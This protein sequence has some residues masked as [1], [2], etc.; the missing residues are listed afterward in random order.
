MITIC[1][2]VGYVV[3]TDDAEKIN[4]RRT[5]GES[6]AERMGG[7][8]P[9][10]PSGAQAH[11]GNTVRENHVY[12][13]IVVKVMNDALEIVNLQVL[14]DGSDTYW[15]TSVSPDQTKSPKPGTWHWPARS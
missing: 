8:N 2:T 13:A 1:R 3:S 14:L 4:R 7:A 10:W 5:T 9:T 12:P 15:A 6:I 11:I